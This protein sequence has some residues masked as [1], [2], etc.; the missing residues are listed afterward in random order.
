MPSQCAAN[1]YLVMRIDF[2]CCC[3]WSDRSERSYFFE[4]LFFPPFETQRARQCRNFI[5][6]L[7]RSE[8]QYQSFCTLLFGHIIK[9]QIFIFKCRCCFNFFYWLFCLFRCA[10]RYPILYFYAFLCV[11]VCICAPEIVNKSHPT[12]TMVWKLITNWISEISLCLIWSEQ[13]KISIRS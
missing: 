1:C 8:Y 6:H 3:H 11:S 12:M 2:Y 4:L 5:V 13:I 9:R 10:W 7:F